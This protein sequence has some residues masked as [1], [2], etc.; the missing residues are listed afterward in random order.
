MLP[1]F[2]A[3]KARSFG[4]KLPEKDRIVL[5]PLAA[6][7]LLA[8]A[9]L[10]SDSALGGRGATFA[11]WVAMAYGLV[12]IPLSF[13]LCKTKDLSCGRELRNSSSG[14]AS[15]IVAPFLVCLAI[16]M[17]FGLVEPLAFTMVAAAYAFVVLPVS[18]LV[19]VIKAVVSQNPETAQV[20]ERTD[21]A[22]REG[23]VFRIKGHSTESRK[24]PLVDR[25]AGAVVLAFLLFFVGSFA[26]GFFEGPMA[27]FFGR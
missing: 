22:T 4:K 23:P 14:W 2:L 16:G 8:A 17:A 9:L 3:E 19:V 20:P 6:C 11:G 5:L 10:L 18:V 12:G 21:H 15:T 27:S 1:D 25:I 24:K 13:I 26:I 7:L